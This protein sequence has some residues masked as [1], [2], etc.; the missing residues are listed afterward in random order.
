M[1]VFELR[2]NLINDYEA[3]VRGFL[4]I[5]DE[6]I[7]SKIDEEFGGGLLWPDP[8]IQL[9]PSFEPGETIEQLVTEGILHQEC[10]RIFRKGKSSGQGGAE[11]S[12][13]TLHRHQAEAVKIAAQGHNYVLTTGTGSGKSL[14]YIIPIVDHVLRR[15]SGRGIQAIIV[16]PM[17]AL[18]NSQMGELEKFLCWGYPDNNGPVTYARY[19]GQDDENRRREIIADPPD[20]ILTNYVMLELLLTRVHE[21]QL[22]TAA[23]GLRFLVLDELHT[24][25]GRQGADVSLLVRRARDAFEADK[26][27]CVGT[28]ATLAGEGSYDEQRADVASVAS[29]LFGAQVLAENVIGETL[30]RATSE[31]DLA[32]PEFA[33][34]LRERLGGNDSAPK[35]HD[36]FLQDPL[37]IWI[38]SS[39][40]LK[41]EPGTGR[42]VR[43][44]PLS[45]S[46]EDGAAARL[47]KLTGVPVGKCAK[48]IEEQL[49]ASYN[50]ENPVTGVPVFAFRLHQFISRGDTAY[51]SLESEDKRHLTVS[52]QRFVPGDRS[53]LLFPLVFCRECGQEYYCVRRTADPSGAV[54]EDREL[55]DISKNEEGEPG[56][57]HVNTQDPWPTALDAVMERLPD[58][59]LEEHQGRPR[60]RTAR[61]EYLPQLVRIRPDG[62]Q[63][64]DGLECHYLPAP[65]RFCL[66]CGM[67]YGFRQRSDFP[68]LASLGTGGRSTA[69]TILSLSS[70]RYLR[71]DNSLPE[72]ARKL[73]SFTDNRQ[74]ASLQAG[75]FNDFIEVGLLRSALCSAAASTGPKGIRHD[76]LVQKVFDALDLPLAMYASNPD[77]RFRA[78]EETKS[79][80]QSVLGYRLYRDL[81]RGWRITVPNLEQCG[82]IEIE[83]PSLQ[84]LCAAEDVWESCHPALTGAKPESRAGIAK[85]LLDY[86]RR[87]LA[88]KVTYLD[89][90]TQERITQRSDQYLSLPWAIDENEVG[91]METSAVLYPRSRRRGDDG[92]NVYLSARG[93]FGQYLRRPQTLPGYTDHLSVQETQ[94]MCAQLLEA[95]K[96][97]GLTQRV[98]E[99]GGEAEVPGYQLPASAIVWVAGDGTKPFFDPIRVPRAPKTG[100]RTNPFFVAFYKTVAGDSVGIEAKEHTAQVRYEDRE[101]RE[102]RFRDGRLP[103]LYCSPTMELGVDIA[104]LN[105]VNMRNIPPTPAN[106]AQ[107]SGRAGRSGQPALVFTYCSNFSSH[108]QY[109]FRQPELMV[110]GQVLPPRLELANEDLVRAHVQAIW[111]SEASLDL[112]TSLKDILDVNGEDP[113]LHLLDSVS[114]TISSEAAKRTAKVRA[115]RMLESI[116][117]ALKD[118]DWYSDA[119]LNEVL[120]AIGRRFDQSCERWRSLY[121]S[122][123]RQRILQN[124][125]IMDSSRTPED[126]RRAKRLRAEAEAQVELLVDTKRVAE[127]DFYSYRYFASEGFLPGYNF[128]RLPISAY[129]PGRRQ[130]GRRDEFLSRP[131]FLAI[132]EFGPR[133]VVYHEGSRYRINKVILPIEETQEGEVVITTSAKQCG[134]CGYMH[135]LSGESNWD[136]CQRCGAKLGTP[137]TELFRMQNVSTCRTDKINSDEEERLRL[138]YEMRT[139]V[140]FA[141]KDGRPLSLLARVRS[142]GNQLATLTYGHAANIWRINLGWTRRANKNEHGFLLDLERGYW[143]R[144]QQEVGDEAENPMSERKKRVVPFVEDHKNCLMFEPCEQLDVSTMATL[145]AALKNAIQ[146]EYQLEGSELAAEPLPSPSERNLILFYEAAE[147]GAGVL[148][149]LANT[150]ESLSRVAKRALRLCHYDPDTGE[151]LRRA[152]GAREDCT[153]ACYDCLMS[154]SNQRDHQVLDREKARDFLMSL[155]GAKVEASPAAIP[156][157][158]H[159]A[160]LMRLCQ[161]NLEKNWL[162]FLE[163]R[164][165]RLPSKAQHFIEACATRP[166]FLYEDNQTAVYVD[167]PH[168][169]HPERQARD[170][171]QTGRMEDYGYIVLRFGHRDDWES[172]IAAHPNIFGEVS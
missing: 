82:L 162:T 39:L 170:R 133:A 104:E 70:I 52:G 72:Q 146:I 66:C 34:S 107:R 26:L 100:G 71:K 125:I 97:G 38:E 139:G 7:A 172:I 117:D 88:I 169:D 148:K 142:N 168:H 90:D 155:A 141:E 76:E 55:S 53:R 61:R 144:N 18:A 3:Y 140:R 150:P 23:K 149:R 135:P 106:Y 111:L 32:Q 166:D 95:L 75:H 35:D 143:S 64:E 67:A 103:I 16:Y 87:E 27:Q 46:G 43:Q 99:P 6:R 59:W 134:K 30:K 120:A 114:T 60:V 45:V 4:Q 36:A 29:V 14:S 69:T 132:A 159:L 121:R 58:D 124:R 33:A 126:K 131:R 122:A 130:R 92:G 105:V 20:I 167:G 153:A 113:S 163:D 123:A 115:Q 15:G 19:T 161:S 9:N 160:K 79:A 17:N 12:S 81:K 41:L 102:T 127:A 151:D 91:K 138:G 119:W 50:C 54:F 24:Y 128:P 157:G 129:V 13:L 40:G 152:P 68:K 47:S 94:D 51:A 63:G 80:L 28:S 89:R 116:G 156:R 136:L 109:F 74:D 21:K 165:L 10:L 118:S 22:I 171:E 145:Q 98:A 8:L 25:R 37:S 77:V 108:D 62:K 84:E 48:A 110:A 86:M 42:L 57:L 112:K 2:S 158:E 85:T 1:N 73:L 164:A 5:Q 154:Y 101:E 49:L 56:F 31:V 65:F 83:Y 44:T 96:I 137:F 78:L 11:G 93:G 147:G